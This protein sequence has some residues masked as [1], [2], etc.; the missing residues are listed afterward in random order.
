MRDC[1][2][3]IVWLL[4]PH[5]VTIS[6]AERCRSVIQSLI[7][8][9]YLQ[10]IC[11][12]E[13]VHSGLFFSQ[14]NISVRFPEAIIIVRTRIRLQKAIPCGIY[15]LLFQKSS[16]NWKSSLFNCVN[17]F[18]SFK[19]SLAIQAG[20]ISELCMQMYVLPSV[21]LIFESS[22]LIWRYLNIGKTVAVS[23]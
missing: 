6:I 22:K 10:K 11:R 4:F 3:S 20:A 8:S 17:I 18:A 21:T 12:A 23:A 14:H 16:P 9:H 19:L 7:V 5:W 2:N 13:E 15:I 1:L